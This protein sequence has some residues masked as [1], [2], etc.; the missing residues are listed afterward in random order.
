M[1][2]TRFT[3]TSL[4]LAVGLVVAACGG[5]STTTT[6][7]AA[8]STTAAPTTTVAGGSPLAGQWERAESTYTSLDG[9]IIEVDAV[10]ASAVILTVPENEY[11]F[12][13]GDVKWSE[14][15]QTSEFEYSFQD[16]VRQENT[17]ATSYVEGIIQLSDDGSSLTMTFPTTGTSQEWVRVEGS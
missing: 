3:P 17:G 15:E 12:A 4:I 11:Q 2:T 13:A 9:M 6:A 14:I 5:E 8:G 10:G 7:V 16:L 1:R